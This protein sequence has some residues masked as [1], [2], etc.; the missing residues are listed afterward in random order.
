MNGVVFDA[1]LIRRYD[2]N[3]PRY[4]SY[5]TA[6]QF[7]SGFE[8]QT[9]LQAVKRSNNDPIPRGLSLYL[10]VPF[11]ANPCFYCGCTRIITR[12]PER[13][14]A[15]MERLHREIGMQGRL[16]DRDRKMEQ[17]HFSGGTPT[18][19]DDDQLDALFRALQASFSFGREET[20][21]FSIE[22]DPRT[23]GV[24]R[25]DTLAELGFNRL[26][27]GIQDFDPEV[28]AAVNRVQDPEHCLRLIGT[29]R[30]A[31]FRSVA[32]DLIYGL[33]R[34]TLAGFGV[35]L[36]RIAGALP[37]RIAIYGYAHL[38]EHFKAQRQIEDAG[39]PGPELRLELLALAV[40]RLTRAGYEYIGMDHF[41]RPGDD[42][43][44]AREQGTLQRNFQG[45]ST[46]AGLDLVGLGLSAIGHVGPVYVQNAKT[47][48][49]YYGALD[50]GGLPVTGGCTASADDEVRAD[51]INRLMC[52]EVLEYL[53]LE[54]THHVRF[55]EY[56]AAELERLKPMAAD[57][58]VEVGV[59]HIRVL[60]RG[61]VLLRNLAMIFDAYLPKGE[62]AN[63]LFSKVI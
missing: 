1:G 34:Q 41:A 59:S 2:V 38:P 11:C 43:V 52:Y 31:G 6:R 22:V 42:L 7:R 45:Y 35:T 51:V 8:A 58:L 39:L 36:E 15:Y 63:P 55:R 46:R 32:V 50:A 4:T 16:F 21:E 10:H 44:R 30:D 57:G 37:D 62:P 40:E 3:G 53:A 29:A 47:L 48:D 25:L 18:G 33:P 23:V 60:P 27:L 56:F 28:Q 54:R 20:R 14:T 5:P 12:D 49:G 9:Y 24:P 19:L 17:L 13:I 26:S 61:R